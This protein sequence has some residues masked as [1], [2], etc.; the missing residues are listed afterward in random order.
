VPTTRRTWTEEDARWSAQEFG[1]RDAD[2][3]ID[4]LADLAT[5]QDRIERGT[6]L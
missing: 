6:C 2:R 5:T 1:D 3:R 4:R